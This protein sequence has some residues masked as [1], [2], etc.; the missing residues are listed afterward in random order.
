MTD[1]RFN[2]RIYN[3]RVTAR[4]LSNMLGYTQAHLAATRKAEAHVAHE[5]YRGSAFWAE[6]A[7]EVTSRMEDEID[8]C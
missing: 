8:E 7:L 4:R 3:P 1:N 6:V 2:P 5:S